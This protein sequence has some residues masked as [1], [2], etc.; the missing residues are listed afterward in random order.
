VH[1]VL[2]YKFLNLFILNGPRLCMHTLWEKE[3]RKLFSESEKGGKES[4]NGWSAFLSENN[5]LR[6]PS[7]SR[8]V[9]PNKEAVI[10]IHLLE[11]ESLMSKYLTPAAGHVVRRKHG[12]AVPFSFF[13]CPGP[14]HRSALRVNNVQSWTRE[15]KK[16]TPPL[17]LIH[18]SLLR[19]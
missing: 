10:S 19:S 4:R 18:E 14:L 2:D 3:R 12:M 8:T 5:T 13:P 17:R 9:P 11:R 7:F 1:P 6:V 16:E 15:K